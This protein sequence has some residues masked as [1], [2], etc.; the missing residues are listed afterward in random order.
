M[1][2]GCEAESRRLT[3]K[4]LADGSLVGRLGPVLGGVPFGLCPV[5][6]AQRETEEVTLVCQ[7][8]A[9][10]SC[11]LRQTCARREQVLH[12]DELP[13]D[14]TSPTADVGGE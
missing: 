6:V 13:I 7:Q 1:F 8:P 10:G 12:G 5:V 11:L 14:E 2:F 9:E 3:D 4:D